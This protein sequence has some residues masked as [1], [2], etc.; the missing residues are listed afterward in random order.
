MRE[1]T[2]GAKAPS[3]ACA[4]W[5]WRG[6]GGGNLTWEAEF[7]IVGG[8]IGPPGAGLSAALSLGRSYFRGSQ[9]YAPAPWRVRYSPLIFLRLSWRGS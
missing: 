8:A 1:L 3:D 4:S 2:G 9:S 6:G 5:T 7:C